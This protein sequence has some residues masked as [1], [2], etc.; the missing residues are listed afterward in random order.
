[1]A[2]EQTI[3]TMRDYVGQC[4]ATPVED[5]I[6]R[7]EWGEIDFEK[8][9]VD[10]VRMFGLLDPLKLL[11][12]EILPDNVAAQINSQLEA[13]KN[14]MERIR[15]FRIMQKDP[16]GTRDALCNELKGQ[17]DVVYTQVTPH[18]PYLAYMRGDVDRNITAL[19]S[20]VSEA[21]EMVTAAKADIV[22]KTG[23]IEKLVSTAREVA[24]KAGVAIFTKDF[25]G[26]AERHEKESVI[27]LRATMG[28][29]AATALLAMLFIFY[30]PT[31]TSLPEL[32]QRIA[33]K[34]VL[35]GVLFTATVWCG[36]HY[37]GLRHQ[38]AVNH[39]RANALLTF[40]A[41]TQAAADDATRNA[42][43]LE[44]TRSIFAH[45]NTGYI[46]ESQPRD[47]QVKIL[48]VVRAATQI[49]GQAKSAA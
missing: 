29:A 11:P 17:V 22:S 3:K 5:L 8:A 6:R 40:Q 34:L 25:K 12:L 44:T 2:T 9:R 24:A 13:M 38:A 31:S 23:E 16:T 18:I 35:L 43:L 41:F 36:R 28:L 19:V 47:G 42:V 27:W 37:K 10:L 32:V 46:E 26:E 45:A 30:F 20:K 15:G 4:T 7:K 49:A 39:H 48:E 21:G 14:L 33:A 1:M